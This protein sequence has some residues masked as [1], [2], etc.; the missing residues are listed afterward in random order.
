MIRSAFAE[1]GFTGALN[2]YRNIDRNWELT[3]RL[4]GRTVDV[5]A[6]FVAGDRDPVLRMTPPDAM[7]GR[8]TSLRTVI[9]PGVGHWTQQ[10][11][12][13]EVTHELLEHLRAGG[14]A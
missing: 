1:T 13:A 5:P 10:E 11:R 14:R 9:L 3:E 8:V 6:L 4:E 12:P 7:V 2:W